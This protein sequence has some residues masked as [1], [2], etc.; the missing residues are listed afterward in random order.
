MLKSFVNAASG[1]CHFFLHE[2]NGKIQA[3]V[4]VLTLIA[5]YVFKVTLNECAIILLCIALVIGLEMIN[6]ALEKFCDIVQ[7]EYHPTIKIV[8][9]VAA[10]AVLF[11]S[12]LSVATGCIIFLPKILVLL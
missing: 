10:G 4:A 7:K 3:A 12:V 2:R 1:L 9:D 6:T 11:A 8:K 5:S